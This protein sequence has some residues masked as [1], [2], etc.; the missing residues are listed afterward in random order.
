MRLGI[1]AYIGHFLFVYNPVLL[2][3]GFLPMILWSFFTACL[4]CSALTWAFEG[5]VEERI[6]WPW[7]ILALVA[8]GC[9]LVPETISDLFGLVIYVFMYWKFRYCYKKAKKKEVLSDGAH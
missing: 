6:S 4:R 5:V 1:V 9:L 3:Q 8:A 7:R 2:F